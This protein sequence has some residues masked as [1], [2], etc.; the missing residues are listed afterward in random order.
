MVLVG[1]ISLVVITILSKVSKALFRIVALVFICAAA[2]ALI[3]GRSIGEMLSPGVDIVFERN[4]IVELHQKFCQEDRTD[5]TICECVVGPIYKD[6]ESRIGTRRLNNMVNKPEELK[7]ETL[8]SLEFVKPNINSCLKERG[9]DKVK[10][11]ELIKQL[12][13]LGN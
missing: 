1:I 3:S 13:P 6:V 5:R 2:Y 11:L 10:I 8:N 12:S 9:R 4:N 7:Q